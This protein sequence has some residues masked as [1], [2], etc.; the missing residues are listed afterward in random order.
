MVFRPA[1]FG[2]H[3]LIPG[4]NCSDLIH[5]FPSTLQD[6]PRYIRIADAKADSPV[7]DTIV[8]QKCL[9]W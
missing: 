3:G 6:R 9:A 1:S 2:H 7:A 4:L 8:R 5:V